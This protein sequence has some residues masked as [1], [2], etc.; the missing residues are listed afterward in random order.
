MTCRHSF[1]LNT[2][3]PWV[4]IPSLRMELQAKASLEGHESGEFRVMA[5]DQLAELGLLGQCRP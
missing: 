4:A 1:R 5:L 3:R 2:P